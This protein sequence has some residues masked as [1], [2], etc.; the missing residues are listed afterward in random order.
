VVK[1]ILVIL[2]KISGKKDF[3]VYIKTDISHVRKCWV[4]YFDNEFRNKK[5]LQRFF[6]E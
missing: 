1:Y 4:F 5:F 3:L 2:W 6:D